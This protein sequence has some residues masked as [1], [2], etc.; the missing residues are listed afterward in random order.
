MGMM[1]RK[2]NAEL[3]VVIVVV[4]TFSRELHRVLM[5]YHLRTV[6]TPD[7]TAKMTKA[8]IQVVD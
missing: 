7:L 2:M 5:N 6:V 1:T 4:I 3:F 8:S